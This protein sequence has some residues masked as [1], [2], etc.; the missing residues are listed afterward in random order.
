MT[1]DAATGQTYQELNRLYNIFCT[2]NLNVRYYGSRAESFESRERRLQIAV[3]ALSAAAL[4][5]L[6]ATGAEPAR[7]F[8]AG[9]A[10]MATVL[11]TID[12]FLGWK[13]KAREMHFL[14]RAH[15]Q[16]C[17]QI[18][19]TMT[20]IRRS[21]EIT[22]ELTG[23]SKMVH[24]TFERLQALDEAHPDASLINRLDQ[25]VRSAFPPD[26]IWTNL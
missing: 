3:A 9:L 23:A 17:T 13:E 4:V 21:G 11:A 19:A 18:E 2:T 20:K 5:I 1:T 24:D 14:H 7:W 16:L 26:Y 10:G 8:C 6:L 15:G 25:Q 22:D 12:P